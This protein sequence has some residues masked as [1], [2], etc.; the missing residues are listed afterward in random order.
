MNQSPL[1]ENINLFEIDLPLQK[2]ID[3][4]GNADIRS[5]LQSYGQLLG[6]PETISHGFLANQYEP[7]FHSHDSKGKRID[8]IEFHPS[9]HALMDIGI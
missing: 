5:G 6:T 4:K 7:I 3:E 9:Y 8:S 1:F 2:I